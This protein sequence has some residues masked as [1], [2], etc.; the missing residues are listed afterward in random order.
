MNRRE[1]IRAIGLSAASASLLLEGCK[2]DAI[3]K[4]V[5]TDQ[6]AQAEAGRQAFAQAE[7]R[8]ER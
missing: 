1:S 5:A 2:D 3:K 4:E 6:P 7:T 8:P